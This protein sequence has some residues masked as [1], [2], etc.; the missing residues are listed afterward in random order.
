MSEEWKVT[1]HHQTYTSQW[2]IEDGDGLLIASLNANTLARNRERSR[3]D[4]EDATRL[5]AAA[6]ALLVACERLV[7]SAAYWSE[8]G[9]PLGIVDDLKAA[10][11]KARGEQP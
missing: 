4:Q 8:H 2:F 9:V 3:A 5:M 7:E 10:V 11:A 6:P 1:A